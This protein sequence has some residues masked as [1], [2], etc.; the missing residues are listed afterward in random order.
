METKIKKCQMC[1]LDL[2]EDDITFASRYDNGHKQFQSNCRECQ[3][4]Y[5]RSHYLNNKQ[6]YIDKAKKYKLTL[7]NWFNDYKKNLSCEICGE[8]RPWVLDFHHKDPKEK[9]FEVSEAVR[10]CNKEKLIEEIEKCITLC[11]NCHRDLH[12]K[13]KKAGVA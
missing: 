5:R 12:Y 13:E 1:K 9:D 11:S 8:K 6:K 2:P 10:R 7:I 3:K 4:K